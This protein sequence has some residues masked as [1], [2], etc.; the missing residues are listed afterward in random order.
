MRKEYFNCPERDSYAEHY[1]EE[2][3]E[4]GVFALVPVLSWLIQGGLITA[5]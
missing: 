1:F 3:E 5:L 2:R 4:R